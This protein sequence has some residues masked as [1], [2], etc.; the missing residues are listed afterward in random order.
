[1]WRGPGAPRTKPPA[2]PDQPRPSDRG[3]QPRR[4]RMAPSA[5][6]E[7]RPRW[8][9]RLRH[10]SIDRGWPSGNSCAASHP[11]GPATDD[12]RWD[13]TS[14]LERYEAL[15][16]ER[17]FLEARRLYER[18]IAEAPDPHRRSSTST[19]TCSGVTGRTRSGMRS[20]SM[21]CDRARPEPRQAPLPADLGPGLDS[22]DRAGDRSVQAAPG[23]V[24]TEV[25]EHR[26]L[27]NAYLVARECRR[28]IA[29][30]DGVLGRGMFGAVACRVG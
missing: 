23:S 5:P 16:E 22:R 11:S 25:R 7:A 12:R 13:G 2:R 6:T 9:Q 4:D 24:P 29:R 19:G 18:A 8:P 10:G 20:C 1:L 30:P 3:A 14:S 17:D 21:S 15:G 26:F 27:A 28:G